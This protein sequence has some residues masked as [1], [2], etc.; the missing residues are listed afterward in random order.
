MKLKRPASC[1]VLTLVAAVFLG[2]AGEILAQAGTS[3]Q[4]GPSLDHF[5]IRVEPDADDH[6]PT[7]VDLV[8]KGRIIYS[9]EEYRPDAAKGKRLHATPVPG[10]ESVVLG[11]FTGGAH[12]CFTNLLW[13][14]SGS[15][16][17]AFSFD[18]EHSDIFDFKDIDGNGSKEII[19]VDWS[20]AYYNPESSSPLF[21]PFASSPGMFR[22]MV[23]DGTRWRADRPGEFGVF[24]RKHL[25]VARKKL[26]GMSPKARREDV[27]SAVFYV[28]EIAY[29]S[30]MV[31][32]NE[33][34][35]MKLL[36]TELPPTWKKMARKIFLDIR[37]AANE[38]DP[39]EKLL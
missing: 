26:T 36:Q 14:V 39:V 6:I 16:E 23:F 3:V 27:S 15:Q 25:E 12:C 9:G 13:T 31:G 10:S 4:D 19:L 29:Y 33:A 21:L 38:F 22:L 24:Y 30:H 32:R 17:M 8:Y 7:V 35:L 20:F 11:L 28:L 34:T 18:L 2:S 37:E 1:L 5:K